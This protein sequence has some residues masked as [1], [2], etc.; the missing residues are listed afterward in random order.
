MKQIK[1]ISL[2]C[3]IVFSIFFVSFMALAWVAPTSTPPN[4]IVYIPINESITGQA[5]VGPLDIL[6]VFR[7]KTATFLAQ[8]DVTSSV[9][10]GS[11][12]TSSDLTV[13]GNISTTKPPTQGNHVAN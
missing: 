11:S 1:S 2:F 7:T 6:G 3:G 10:I 13:Y 8:G 9:T 5:K 4:G 12:A